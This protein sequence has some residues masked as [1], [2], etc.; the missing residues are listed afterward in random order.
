MLSI[1]LANTSAASCFLGKFKLQA[2]YQQSHSSSG[3]LSGGIT[4]TS[5][6]W[7]GVTWQATPAAALIAAV[8]HVNANNGGGNATIYTI[9]GTYNLTKRTLLDFQIATAR[10]SA[11]ANFGLNANSFAIQPHR[12]PTSG[13]QPVGRI[14][15][16]SASFLG[17]PP[18]HACNRYMPVARI[19]LT[20]RVCGYGVYR[21]AGLSK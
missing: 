20:R 17:D 1:S 18:K 13:S 4:T 6:E 3:A 8:Y 12:Q 7:G 10:N 21:G 14:R 15:R 5:Q 16:H 2:V 11:N 9:G 19:G